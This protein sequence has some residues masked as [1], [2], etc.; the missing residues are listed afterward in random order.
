MP[1]VRRRDF[2]GRSATRSMGVASLAPDALTPGGSRFN[3]P[4]QGVG[5]GEEMNIKNS[6]WGTLGLVVATAAIPA[7]AQESTF[8]EEI[9]VTAA[10]RQQTLQEIPVAVSVIQADDLNKSQVLDV[11]DLQFLVPSL[12]VGQ[13][14]TPTFSFVASVT[15]PTT[16]A[17]SH[18]SVSSSTA[19]IVPVRPLRSTTSRIWNA[20]KS[21]ADRKARCSARTLLPA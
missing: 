19:Y 17:S 13:L 9:V 12:R 2:S 7:F 14:Q 18:R 4:H 6:L 15:A 16:R 1:P 11:K 3:I 10:K 21:C 8:L 20:S 5:E